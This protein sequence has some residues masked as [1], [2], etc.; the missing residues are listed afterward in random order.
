MEEE[1]LDKFILD[2]GASP[3]IINLQSKNSTK[4]KQPEPIL[5]ENG[6]INPTHVENVQ[7]T[8]TKERSIKVKCL[9]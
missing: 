7:I 5:T 1:E 3:S 4:L 8:T 2:S 6:I 9:I